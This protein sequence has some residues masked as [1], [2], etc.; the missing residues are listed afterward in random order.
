MRCRFFLLLLTAL[1][2]VTVVFAGEQNMLKEPNVS[3]QFYSNDPKILAR[4][5]ERY[6][7]AATIEP[8]P[9]HI[10]VTI[11]PHAGYVYSGE[12]AG[13]SFKSASR[14]PYKTI[15]IL[16]PSHFYGFDGVSIWNKGAFVTPLGEAA[17]DE[18]FSRQLMGSHE[19]F[20]FDPQAY[21]KEHSLEVEIPFLQKTFKDFKIVPVVMGQ[22]S[23]EICRALAQSLHKI[24]G[25][26]QD[27]LI[28]V[29]SDMSHYH[30][31][32][33]ARKMDANALK[34]IK[35]LNPERFW[36]LSRV[37]FL[38]M[39]GYVPVTT[40]L[41]YAK[42]RGLNGVE[43]LRYANSGDVSG[44]KQ[45]V[46]GYS[47]VVFYKDEAPAGVSLLSVQQ[48]KR[49]LEIARATMTAYLKNKETLTF[50]EKDPR[51][52]EPEGAF[53]TIHNRGQLR[54]CIGHIIARV[55]LVKTVRDVAIAAATND[56]RFD[57]VTFDELP[58]IDIEVSVLSKPKRVASLDE[59]LMG[60]DGVVMAQGDNRGV[61]LPQVATDTGWS[62]EEFLAQLC[63]Q[64]CGLPA[65]CYK[66][67]KTII[68]TFTAQVFSETQLSGQ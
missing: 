10:E 24:I 5:V 52:R 23:L 9:K 31:D 29:S 43:I 63:S 40:A 45:R 7:S 2:L 59:I 25:N 18:E 33:T 39:C 4:D 27:V 22:A 20:T 8:S 46:V 57:P 55:P 13:Y 16:A 62:K 64:K 58:N 56:P 65:D 3:G 47:S 37:R 42:Q 67:P 54:G 34:T 61:F 68:E 17:V 44:D 36:E 60:R 26:R 53:V 66:D 12:V 6:L 51:L 15:V 50:D 32:T 19:K 41:I 30:D 49:L 1:C 35:E 38:E 11:A 14:V 28:V 48:K 21:E